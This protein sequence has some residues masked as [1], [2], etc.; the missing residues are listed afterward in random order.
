MFGKKQASVRRFLLAFGTALLIPV[1][2]FAAVPIWNYAKSERAQFERQ[3]QVAAHN[4]I[5]S[6]DLELSKLQV[7]V[8]ALATSPSIQARDYQSFQNQAFDALRL[9]SS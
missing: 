8:E 5:A 6:V 1:L 4:L 9:W 3:A 2:G 7:A